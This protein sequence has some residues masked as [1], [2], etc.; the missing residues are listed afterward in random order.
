MTLKATAPSGQ[1][2][3]AAQAQVL[4]GF[5]LRHP[6]QVNEQIKPVVPRQPRQIRRRLGDEGRGL[7]RAALAARFLGLRT[8]LRAS[9]RAL[10]AALDLGQKITSKPGST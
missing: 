10:R 2:A 9:G 5:Q 4:F 6:K 8:S 1:L 3:L 7:I